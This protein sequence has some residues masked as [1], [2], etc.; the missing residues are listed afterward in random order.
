MDAAARATLL[1]IAS[2]KPPSA[3]TMGFNERQGEP[4]REAVRAA[5]PPV[6]DVTEMLAAFIASTAR[7]FGS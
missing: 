1:E 4:F 3:A 2:H 7:I 5:M 6:P